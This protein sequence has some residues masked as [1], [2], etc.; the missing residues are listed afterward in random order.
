GVVHERG[1]HHLPAVVEANVFHQHLPG[2]L[3]DAAVD[4]S[5]QQHR[6]EHGADVVDNAVA[7]D[8]GL[9]G[10]NVDFQLAD[11]AAIRVIVHRRLVHGGGGKAWLHIGGNLCRHL[12]IGG[13]FLHGHGAV[14]FARREH[15][16][17]ELHV[18]N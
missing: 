15:A 8:D 9:A 13:G 2:A 18:G 4:L 6:I 10:L 11:V 1:G 3:R 12:R 5:V 17:G 7:H 14:G 16:V